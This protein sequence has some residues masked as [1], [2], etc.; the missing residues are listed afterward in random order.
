MRLAHAECKYYW[1]PRPCLDVMAHFAMAIIRMEDHATSGAFYR[2]H[3]DLV[4]C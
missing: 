2:W 4:W 1:H 3:P